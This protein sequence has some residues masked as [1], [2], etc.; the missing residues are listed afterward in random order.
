M[1]QGREEWVSQSV[2]QSV[3]ITE[4]LEHKDGSRAVQFDL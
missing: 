3:S 1:N 2:N 4:S